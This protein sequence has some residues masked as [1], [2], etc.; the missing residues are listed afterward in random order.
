MAKFSWAKVRVR[1]CRRT[2]DG[3][4][5]GLNR[6]QPTTPWLVS[7]VIFKGLDWME[8]YYEHLQMTLHSQ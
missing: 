2:A 4:H 5:K 6:I 7:P 3:V 8:I 1:P